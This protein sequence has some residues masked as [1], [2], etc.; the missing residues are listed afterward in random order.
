MQSSSQKVGC[1]ECGFHHVDA[2][3]IDTATGKPH[4]CDADRK[5]KWQNRL[6]GMAERE[7]EKMERHIELLER[8]WRLRE[9]APIKGHKLAVED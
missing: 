2:N 8:R 9:F 6:P 3:G 1:V 4:E 7:I 5:F